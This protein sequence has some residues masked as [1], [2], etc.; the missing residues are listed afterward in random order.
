MSGVGV[1]GQADLG[2]LRDFETSSGLHI[3]PWNK[4]GWNGSLVGV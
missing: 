4:V 3:G 1:Q 2:V